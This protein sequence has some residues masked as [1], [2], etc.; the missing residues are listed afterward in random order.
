[1]SA[2]PAR[3]TGPVPAGERVDRALPAIDGQ[4]ATGARVGEARADG[5]ER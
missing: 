2:P 3:G 1:V 5:E 4:G